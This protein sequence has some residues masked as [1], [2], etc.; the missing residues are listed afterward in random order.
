MPRSKSTGAIPGRHADSSQSDEP[1]IPAWETCAI[2][3]GDFAAD[4]PPASQADSV[5]HGIK[6]TCPHAAAFHLSCL[7]QEAQQVRIF[8]CPLCRAKFGFTAFC[9]CGAELEEIRADDPNVYGGNGVRCDHCCV[10][11]PGNHEVY[12]CPKAKSDMHP[13]GYDVCRKCAGKEPKEPIQTQEPEE[14]AQSET[15]GALAHSSARIEELLFAD[16]FAADNQEW[17]CPTCTLLNEASAAECAACGR[18]R[19]IPWLQAF[20]MSTIAV[21]ETA[22]ELEHVLQQLSL[23]RTALEAEAMAMG[24]PAATVGS[25][26]VEP[27]PD[28]GRG[29]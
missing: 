12:H 3:F 27:D 9:I 17:Q 21:E 4:D 16:E 24:L 23:H 28:A 14:P 5:R 13:N 10:N 19:P 2:C 6:F 18:I 15:I 7:Q 1:S 11:V 25:A 20:E 8:H 22:D 29:D 26:G